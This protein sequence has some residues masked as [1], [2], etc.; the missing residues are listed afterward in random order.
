MNRFAWLAGAL[1]LIAGATA[2]LSLRW[3]SAGE[4]AAATVPRRIASITLASDEILAELAPDRVIAV[5]YLVDDPDISNAAGVY[6]ASVP[7][8]HE[9]DVERLVAMQPGLLCVAGYNNADFLEVVRRCRIPT[10]RT[11][12]SG[13]IDDI[14]ASILSLGKR[15]GELEKARLLVGKMRQR[16]AAV[17]ERVND[18]PSRPRVMYWSGGHTAGEGTTIDEIIRAA[19]GRNA[20]SRFTRSAAV[21]PEQMLTIDPDVVLVSHWKAYEADRRLD[22]QPS[23]RGLRAVREGKVIAIEARYLTTLSHTVAEGVE[24]LARQLHPDRFATEED[25]P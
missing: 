8:L 14:A 21:A 23:L 11:E 20:A 18:V 3:N 2:T 19:G 12:A 17:V 15:I 22:N 24:R 7:R 1:I 16:I 25:E 4:P 9:K 10:H 13:S 5:T 6:P